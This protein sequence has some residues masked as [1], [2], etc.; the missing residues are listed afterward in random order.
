MTDN[1]KARDIW[2]LHIH[3]AA[4]ILRLDHV[5]DKIAKSIVVMVGFL[6]EFT[7]IEIG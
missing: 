2:H 7:M 5:I 4:Q 6:E 1:I 3:L